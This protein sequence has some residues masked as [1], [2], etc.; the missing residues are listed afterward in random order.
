MA[1]TGCHGELICAIL[2]EVDQLKVLMTMVTRVTVAFLTMAGVP[3][4]A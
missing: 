2:V 3:A 1:P 4:S